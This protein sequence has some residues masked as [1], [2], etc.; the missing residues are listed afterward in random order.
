MQREW[1]WA[2]EWLG[3]HQCDAGAS[4]TGRCLVGAELCALPKWSMGIELACGEW[5]HQL[6]RPTHQHWNECRGGDLQRHGNQC[7]PGECRAWHVCR[8]S[9]GVQCVRMLGLDELGGR[10][11]V[12]QRI[13]GG[14]QVQWRPTPD[15][16]VQ[17]IRP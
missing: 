8:R 4:G 12:L 13:G 11:G 6:Q 14:G 5:S 9:A 15:P 16:Q 3:I 2:M 1:L 10:D 7:H 17:L